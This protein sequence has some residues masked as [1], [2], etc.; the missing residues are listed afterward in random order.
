M[1]AI[2]IHYSGE[3]VV[4]HRVPLNV[5]ATT[6]NHIQN[7]VSRSYLDITRTHGVFKHA[8]M[9]AKDYENS[10]FLVGDP[11]EGGYILDFIA[12]TPL[13]NKIVQRISSALSPAFEKAK[14]E[15][16]QKIEDFGT[17]IDLQKGKILKELVKPR[18]FTKEM[19]NPDPKIVRNYGDRSI[20]KEIDQI[21][22]IIRKETLGENYFD[23]S[24][25]PGQRKKFSFNRNISNNFHSV[26]TTKSIGNPLE[27]FGKLR[28]L[29]SGTKVGKFINSDSGRTHNLRFKAEVDI[30]KVRKFLGDDDGFSFIG[31]P[32]IEY[33][34]YDMYA[35]DIYFLLLK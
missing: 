28:S 23:L 5:L 11:K 14:K 3:L 19:L 31:S 7:T 32:V 21:L 25:N 34:S 1:S 8:R 12:H 17:E 29:D 13:A 24:L 9:S 35:G 27:Y 6:L 15:G 10:I 18:L 26:I 33:G 30:F 16:Y 2:E 4:D 22:A 20:L